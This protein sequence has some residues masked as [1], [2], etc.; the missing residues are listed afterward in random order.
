MIGEIADIHKLLI[1]Y[2]EEVSKGIE[3]AAISL[4]DEAVS[5]LKDSSP[6]DKGKYRKSWKNKVL[7][8]TGYINVTVY[9]AK[10]YR[11][12][13]LLE[14][15][16]AKRNGGRTKAFNHIKPVEKMVSEKF[17]E[18]VEEIIRKGGN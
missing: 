18:S 11:L 8:G 13:H 9:N 3:E 6:I 12:T 4:G 5:V 10:Y 1:D 16:H 7:R 17:V 2:T 15:G 14:Y